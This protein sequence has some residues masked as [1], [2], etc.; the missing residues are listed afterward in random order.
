MFGFTIPAFK[1]CVCVCVEFKP[2]A[3]RSDASTK[4]KNTD[5]IELY[6]NLGSLKIPCRS[7]RPIQP[8]PELLLE[9]RTAWMFRWVAR[10]RGRRARR[11]RR[12]TKAAARVEKAEYGY[13]VAIIEECAYQLDFKS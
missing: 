6:I 9:D 1:M 3:A 12:L 8:K 5:T 2:I 7:R 13:L 10:P 4:Q 11:R